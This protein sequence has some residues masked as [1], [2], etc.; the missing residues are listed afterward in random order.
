MTPPGSEA[1]Q[2]AAYDEERKLGEPLLD[3]ALEAAACRCSTGI[4]S[5][6]QLT[7]SGREGG[8][9][10]MGGWARTACKR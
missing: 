6:G 3:G 4:R 8:A 9:C 5:K 10:V 2:A 1:Q 7:R